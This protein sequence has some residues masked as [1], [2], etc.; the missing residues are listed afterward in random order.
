M[1]IY[2]TQLCIN[3]VNRHLRI[4]F[5]YL[6]MLIYKYMKCFLTNMKNLKKLSYP[7]SSIATSPLSCFGR[8]CIIPRMHCRRIPGYFLRNNFSSVSLPPILINPWS[9]RRVLE[10]PDVI[11]AF[12]V[13][14]LPGNVMRFSWGAWL[15]KGVYSVQHVGHALAISRP[16]PTNNVHILSGVIRVSLPLSIDMMMCRT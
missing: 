2:S 8:Y 7:L 15:R 13:S 4:V 11:G 14:L 5:L 3:N 10:K 1:F 9:V 12:I 6:I 16:R